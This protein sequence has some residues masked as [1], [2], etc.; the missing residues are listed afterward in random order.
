MNIKASEIH[1][2]IS[3][4]P[5]DD[6]VRDYTDQE[7]RV[8]DFAHQGDLYITRLGTEDIPSWKKAP[9]SPSHKLVPGTSKGSN[10]V[11]QCNDMDCYLPPDGSDP[12]RGPILV[13]RDTLEIAHP[14]HANH[15]LPGPSETEDQVV[16]GCTYQLNYSAEE[17]RRVSD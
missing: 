14:E 6:S 1:E 9:K 15:I 3:R 17:R 10:H 4:A 8:G 13:V 2:S 12:L 11:A 7:V 5:V 16:Y